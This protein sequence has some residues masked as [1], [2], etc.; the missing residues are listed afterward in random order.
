MK[1]KETKNESKKQYRQKQKKNRK[2]FAKIFQVTDWLNEIP[3]NFKEFRI[4]AKPDGERLIMIIEGN[5]AE[6]R[7]KSGKSI[8]HLKLK[9]K[10]Y[11]GTIL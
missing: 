9:S 6:L 5:K 1:P 10:N 7:N 4:A 3:S 2:R 11:D 8:C